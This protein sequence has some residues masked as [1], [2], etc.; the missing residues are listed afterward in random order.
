M[1]DLYTLMNLINIATQ[2]YPR[3]T[4]YIDAED[5]MADKNSLI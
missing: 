3:N 5:Q 4:V 1:E 2:Q